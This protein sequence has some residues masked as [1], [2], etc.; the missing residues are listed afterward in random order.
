MA[1]AEAQKKFEKELKRG[2]WYGARA[3]RTLPKNL[4][5][6]FVRRAFGTLLSEAE[7]LHTFGS[8]LSDEYVPLALEVLKKK[9]TCEAVFFSSL[10]GTPSGPRFRELVKALVGL[11]F[12]PS[13]KRTALVN[14]LLKQG[15]VIAAAQATVAAKGLEAWLYLDLLVADGSA[16][17]ADVLL[18]L[19][20]R[21]QK[22]K[23]EDLTFL[24]AALQKGTSPL[25]KAMLASATEAVDAYA[26][27]SKVGDLAERF[28]GERKNFVFHV[29]FET[30]EQR[31]GDGQL[32][33]S[34]W[35]DAR[36]SPQASIFGTRATRTLN[37]DRFRWEDGKTPENSARFPKL[38]SLNALPAW[39]ASVAKGARC[40]WNPEPRWIKSS[41]RG[42]ARAGLLAWLL[43]EVKK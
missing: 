30:V 3:A 39:L 2:T 10:P 34:F 21:A 23:G 4:D 31:H 42:K 28:G 9:K 8:T 29:G 16:E 7:N 6:A 24:E 33:M 19:W 5:P 37:A 27:V 17:S 43:S 41:L 35:F 25:M 11:G 22:K 13:S 15:D 38:A 20:D 14:S 40:R 36:S 1:H 18:P 12:E 32:T 26:K